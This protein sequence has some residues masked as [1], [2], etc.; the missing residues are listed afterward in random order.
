[1]SLQTA[2]TEYPTIAAPSMRPEGVLE[3]VET[4]RLILLLVVFVTMATYFLPFLLLGS[5]SYITIHDNLDGEFVVN[6]LLVKTGTALSFGNSSTVANI[7]N[8]LPRAALP[9]GLNVTVLLFY[10]FTPAWAYIVNFI[11]VHIVAFCGMFLL[12]RKHFLTKDDDY[13]LAGAI[14]ICFFLVPYY[15]T[16]GISVAG[17][18]LLAYAFLNI[19]NGQR[20]W[21]DYLIVLLF[22]LWSDIALIAPFAVSA[23]ALILAIDWVRSRSLNKPFLVALMLL[24]SAYGALQYQLVYSIL[25]SHTFVSNRTSWNRWTDLNVSSNLRKTFE[26]LPITQY[27]TGSFSTLPVIVA[28]GSALVLLVARKRRAGLLDVLAIAIALICLE[29]GF[30]DWLA[31]LAPRSF[32]ASRYYFLLP[33][34]WML[35]FALSLK[36]LKRDKWGFAIAWCLIAVQ[37]GAI[38]KFNTEYANNVGLLA[39]K[40]VYEPSFSRFFAQDLFGDIDRYIAKPKESYRVVTIGMHPTVAQFNGFYTL[41][42]YLTNYSLAYKQR[43]RRIIWKELNKDS[44]LRDYFDGWGNRCYVF[45]SELGL[46]ELCSG[47]NHYVLHNLDLDM[48]QVRAMG[49]E[50][51]ISAARIEDSAQN[52]LTL[53]KEFSSANSFW[54]LY[55]Y[56]LTPLPYLANG[57]PSHIIRTPELSPSAATSRMYR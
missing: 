23:L 28:V 57:A 24:V 41:D 34:L 54:H 7:M 6:Y 29:Y 19:R 46:N 15:T 30:Y 53:E 21:K 3:R 13:L 32:N 10:V 51:V 39:G 40:H 17:Q 25:G 35:V 16:Y 2:L 11:L 44:K 20:N 5:H 22:P 26:L 4:K 49:G 45:S 8:G 52:G 1:V 43:F 50:Y 55:L 9:S 12:L 56:H 27:H 37:A 33:L 48:E 31:W 47:N 42:G 38:L 18:P 14:A 36:E